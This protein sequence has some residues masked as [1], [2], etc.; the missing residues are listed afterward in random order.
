MFD[1]P[2]PIL[3]D[4]TAITISTRDLEQSLKFYQLL[5]FSEVMRFNFPFP[6]IQVSDGQLLIM[7]RLDDNPYFAL[8]YY[9]KETGTIVAD[10]ESKGIRF[11]QK[12]KVSDMIKR[13]VFQSPDGL[14]ISLVTIMDGFMQPPGPTMLTMNQEDYMK[15]EKY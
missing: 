8:T 14:N 7:L 3:G 6:W 2:K 4:I 1:L 13:Y 12:P 5:G 11:S 15:P 9:S 10:L